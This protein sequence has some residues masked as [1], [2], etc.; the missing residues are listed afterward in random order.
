MLLLIHPIPSV[1]DGV[2]FSGLP[3]NINVPAFALQECESLFSIP[4]S[5]VEG[6]ESIGLSL[7][8]AVQLDAVRSSATLTIQDDGMIMCGMS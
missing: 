2:D 6:D 3:L 5:L 8:S 4:D 7:I 1:A